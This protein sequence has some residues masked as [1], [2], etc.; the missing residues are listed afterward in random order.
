[1]AGK[2]VNRLQDSDSFSDT[3]SLGVLLK[4]PLNLFQTNHDM[5]QHL[6]DVSPK[7]IK[8]VISTCER[9]IWLVGECFLAWWKRATGID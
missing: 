6:P 2:I 9:A 5:R 4:N 8:K 7:D 1:M 3:D